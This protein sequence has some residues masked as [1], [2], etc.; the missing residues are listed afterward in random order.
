MAGLGPA[1]HVLC[2]RAKGRR[3]YPA[4]GRAWRNQESWL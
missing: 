4:Q 3:G 1:I 2:L